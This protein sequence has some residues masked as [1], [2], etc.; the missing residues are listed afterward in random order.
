MLTL[1]QKRFSAFRIIQK[2]NFEKKSS[3]SDTYFLNESSKIMDEDFNEK[4]HSFIIENF[5]LFKLHFK[6]SLL[7]H[8][9]KQG[10]TVP[11]LERLLFQYFLT[12]D[13]VSLRIN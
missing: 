1:L 6:L 4:Y 8:L 5:H 13:M 11:E 9:A 7:H 12:H 3:N 2:A 10:K